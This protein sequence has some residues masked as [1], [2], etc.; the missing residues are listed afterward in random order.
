MPKQDTDDEIEIQR[1]LAEIQ[2]RE[3]EDAADY[4]LRMAAMNRPNGR[5]VAPRGMN[6]KNLVRRLGKLRKGP[7]INAKD[8]AF[9]EHMRKIKEKRE[10]DFE[11]GPMRFMQSVFANAGRDPA[12]LVKVLRKRKGRSGGQLPDPW[13]GAKGR[14]AAKNS[15]TNTKRRSALQSQAI[16]L[17]RQGHSPAE[18]AKI[19]KRSDRMV[20]H[21]LKGS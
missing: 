10:K 20:R 16:E 9:V 8:P 17:Q 11:K 1:K 5:H 13:K 14:E 19:L 12:E 2:Q 6:R 3:G 7:P 4:I 15:G 18:I 21:Y